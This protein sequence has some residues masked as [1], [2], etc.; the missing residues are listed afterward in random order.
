MKFKMKTKLLL[1][2][3]STSLFFYSCSSDVDSDVLQ[4]QTKQ[5]YVSYTLDLDAT[6]DLSPLGLSTEESPRLLNSL[7][8]EFNASFGSSDDDYFSFTVSGL[9]AVGTKQEVEVFINKKG[10][11]DV[12]TNVYRKRQQ[13]EVVGPRRLKFDG[14][15]DIPSGLISE[16]DELQLVAVIGQYTDEKDQKLRFFPYTSYTS[17]I[18]TPG[19]VVLNTQGE[20]QHNIPFLLKVGLTR[21]GD[22]KTILKPSSSVKFQPQGAL[23]VFLQDP[24][25]PYA[26]Y[27]GN[28]NTERDD[29]SFQEEALTISYLGEV[30]SGDVPYEETGRDAAVT[31]AYNDID[32]T[33]RGLA[34]VWLPNLYPNLEV[35]FPDEG[36]NPELTKPAYRLVQRGNVYAY[37]K[38]Y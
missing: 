5:D 2:L 14:K 24:G 13:W 15:I 7:K 18:A 6:Q 38:N 31:V 11:D 27:Y 28:D 30:E 26:L 21:T 29:L 3:L 22:S 12:W 10:A 34:I 17:N 8:K 32:V 4:E 9:G 36:T 20:Y 23:L 33:E 1:S 25:T 19:P 16:N 37:V 35:G